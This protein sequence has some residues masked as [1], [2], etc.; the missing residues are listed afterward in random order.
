[1]LAGLRPS[2]VVAAALLFGALSN[3]GKVMGIQAGVPFDLL[4][5]IIALVIM[6]VAAPGLIRT[7]WRIRVSKPQPELAISQQ[8]AA[9]E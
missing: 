4:F 6:F 8:P 2:G 7:I 9:S 5:F 3:G 1:L